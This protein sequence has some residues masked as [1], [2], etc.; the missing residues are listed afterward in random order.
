MFLTSTVFNMSLW[1][2]IQ[3]IAMILCK[4]GTAGLGLHF[5]ILGILPFPAP[6]SAVKNRVQCGYGGVQ[7]LAQVHRDSLPQE[8][9]SWVSSSLINKKLFFLQGKG[10]TNILP[11]GSLERFVCV[12][13]SALECVSETLRGG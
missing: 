5:L 6:H 2:H 10:I 12:K 3:T 13:L 4:E 7:G 11:R 9:T 8:G 1:G